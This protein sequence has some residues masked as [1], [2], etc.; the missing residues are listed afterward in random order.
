MPY[1]Y[2][3]GTSLG[4]ERTL[5]SLPAVNFGVE[6]EMGLLTVKFNVRQTPGSMLD[7]AGGYGGADGGCCVLL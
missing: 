7:N 5:D 2:Y 4:P 1:L 6:G 3:E